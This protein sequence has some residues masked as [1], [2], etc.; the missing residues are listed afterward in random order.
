MRLLERQ[1]DARLR[2]TPNLCWIIWVSSQWQ[3]EA[4]EDFKLEV[5]LLRLIQV[6]GRECLGKG[7]GEAVWRSVARLC[8]GA[9]AGLRTAAGTRSSSGFREKWTDLRDIEEVGSVG[10]GD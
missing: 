9:V 1:G 5:R 3:L 4:T 2:R 6:Q 10:L 8:P 7:V